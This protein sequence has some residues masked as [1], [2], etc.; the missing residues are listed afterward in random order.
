MTAMMKLPVNLEQGAFKKFAY[1]ENY[2][3]NKRWLSSVM[4]GAALLVGAC[5]C[6]L[7]MED[8]S[9]VGGALL[10]VGAGIP[11]SHFVSM[12]CSLKKQIADHHLE[13]PRLVYTVLLGETGVAQ[14]LGEDAAGSVSPVVPWEKVYGAW[15]TKNAI[16][17][18]VLENRALLLPD[19]CI[20]ESQDAVWDFLKSHMA[21]EKLHWETK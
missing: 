5:L 13:K 10:C 6:F 12:R 1:F 19:G 2:I 8:A 7:L 9:L 15:R 16:Y 21:V 18:Y 3:R 17:L 20:S 4:A 14:Q 11:L